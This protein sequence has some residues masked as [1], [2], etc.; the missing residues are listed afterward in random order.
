ATHE[1]AAARRA[2]AEQALSLAQEGTRQE[3][4][5]AAAA[6]VSS[7]RAGIDAAGRRIDEARAAL[8]STGARDARL[9][10]LRGG[11]DALRAQEA[12]ARDA[13]R[14]AEIALGKRTIRAPFSA[15][16]LATLTDAGE[17]ASPGGPIVRLGA[18]DRVKVTFAVPEASRPSLRVGRPV[19]IA[20]DA[21]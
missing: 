2:S 16:V 20:V 1:A 8:R 7:A 19:R 10:A 11:I 6:Q 15:R 4:R 5:D 18:I 14:Q 17:M 3:D 9:A 13:V 12:G 21:L